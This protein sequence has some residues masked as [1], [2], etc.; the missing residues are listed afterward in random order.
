MC[1]PVRSRQLTMTLEMGEYLQL[2]QPLLTRSILARQNSLILPPLFGFL[3]L[4]HLFAGVGA[5]VHPLLL[6]GTNRFVNLIR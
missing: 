5:S 4:F 2:S 3:P 1:R 6:D